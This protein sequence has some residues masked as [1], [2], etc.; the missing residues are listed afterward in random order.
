MA[1]FG[2]HFDMTA[3]GACKTCQIAC[4]DKN[5][6]KAGELFREVRSYEGGS[7]P[8]P[9][10][11]YLSMSCNHCEE[12]L[13]VDNC[14]TGASYKRS[15]D[16]IV[17]IDEDKC[18]GCKYCLWSCPYDARVYFEDKG[19]VGK[20]NMCVDL[21]EEGQN[22]ACVDACVM[23]AIDYGDIDELKAKYPNAVNDLACLPNSN[24]TKPNILIT[25]KIEAKT[26]K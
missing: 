26:M 2:F 8:K 3:C 23:R 7:F 18:V 6:L 24:I 25:P 9:W 19:V 13:C 1:Q 10:I 12:P 14:P 16:G 5:D 15:E 4:N 11:Y 21:L 20:C 17:V 22:P